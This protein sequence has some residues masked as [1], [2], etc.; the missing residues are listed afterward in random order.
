MWPDQV[1]NPGSLTYESDAYRLRYAVHLFRS[2]IFYF[3]GKALSGLILNGSIV[4]TVL[5]CTHPVQL[6]RFVTSRSFKLS[7]I[8]SRHA[9]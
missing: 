3:M 7:V 1:A 4:L 5:I 8:W 6:P 2:E 9:L